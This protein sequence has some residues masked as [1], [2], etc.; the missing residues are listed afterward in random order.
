MMLAALVSMLRSPPLLARFVT[1]LPF[2]R[3]CLLLLGDSPTPSIAT[4]ILL[5]IN[6]ALRTSPSYLRKMELVNGWLVIRHVLP[7]AWSPS[8]H[9][10]AFDMLLGERSSHDPSGTMLACPQIFSGI[11]AS[12]THLLDMIITNNVLTSTPQQADSVVIHQTLEYMLDELTALYSSH[13][14]FKR[15]FKSHQTIHILSTSYRSFVTNLQ[16]LSTLTAETIRSLEKL[17]HFVLLVAL[18]LNR[19]KTP[20]LSVRT[21]TAPGV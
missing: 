18:D 1:A 12:L 10:A 9:A 16:G 2:S 5:L 14:A 20:R 4:Q 7:G 11:L 15:L 17:N 19:D 13:D 3:T 8:T 21:F 6:L